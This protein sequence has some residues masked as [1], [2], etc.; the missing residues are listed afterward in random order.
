MDKS[1][2][3]KKIKALADNGTGGE[4]VN[5]T[6][7]LAVLMKKY[8]I[9]EKEIL[10][11]VINEFE[12]KFQGFYARELT[13]QV[14]YSVIGNL[15]DRKGLF[16]GIT[17]SG[18]KKWFVRCTN[19]EFLEFQAKYKFYRYHFTEDVELFYSAFIDRNDIYPSSDKC[20][21]SNKTSLTDK[22]IKAILLSQRLD[23]HLYYQQIELKGEK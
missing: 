12:I 9:G 16:Q 13:G 23:K 18:K 20:K 22:D 1:E 14:L 19:A 5:A 11:D 8:N 4:K 15:D 10:E 2:L 7:M 17:Y 6:K 3:L 21:A